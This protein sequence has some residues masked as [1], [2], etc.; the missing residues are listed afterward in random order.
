MDLGFFVLS[1]SQVKIYTCMTV[2]NHG[3]S[4]PF[5]GIDTHTLM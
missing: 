4:A 2:D 3:N 5:H 1:V